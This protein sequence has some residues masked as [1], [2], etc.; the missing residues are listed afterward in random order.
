ML[1]ARDISGGPSETAESGK[2]TERWRASSLGGTAHRPSTLVCR[3]TMQGWYGTAGV[4]PTS[5][6]QTDS[7]RVV[8]LHKGGLVLF[9]ISG[10]AK[11]DR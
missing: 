5:R 11:N 3:H 1:G 8:C 6:Y 9:C 4:T 7:C 10:D 2:A